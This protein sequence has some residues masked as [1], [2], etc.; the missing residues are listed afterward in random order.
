M[1]VRNVIFDSQGLALNMEEA[2]QRIIPHLHKAVTEGCKRVIVLRNDTDVL[3][4][5]FYY[6]HEFMSNG[7][8]ELWMK[9]G[10]GGSSRFIPLH[11]LAS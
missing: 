1:E 6:T 3:A 5:L 2:D 11:F 10:T 9:F 7:L 8:F 4:L